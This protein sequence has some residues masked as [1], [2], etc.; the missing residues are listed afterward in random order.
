MEY[1]RRRREELGYT[2]KELA[3]QCFCDAT[4]ISQIEHRR[5][6]PR[7]V[8][9][10]HLARALKCSPKRLLKALLH[11]DD[12]EPKAP[13]ASVTDLQ[14]EREQRRERRI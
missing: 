2:Q 5:L 12:D 7:L 1:V 8:L 10:D 3:G 11:E 9:F 6:V 14:K 13:C 4:T